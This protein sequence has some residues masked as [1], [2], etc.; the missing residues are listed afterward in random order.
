MTTWC[1]VNF[2]DE[3]IQEVLKHKEDNLSAGVVTKDSESGL[4]KRNSKVSWIK[5]KDICNKVFVQLRNQVASFNSHIHLDNI[6][7]L[8][9]SEYSSNE[10]Y[11]W[12]RDTHHDPYPD[13][14]IRK[15]SFSVFLNNNFSGGEFDLELY[16]PNE[17]KRY[18]EIK[19]KQN[20]NCIIFHSDMWH[21]VRPVTKGIR[22]S[23]VGWTLGPN[24]S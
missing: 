15:I 1:L 2:P 4:I 6:E 20:A 10:E 3:L 7:P 23:I 5:N 8:Q 22:K 12:H 11:G 9:Y 14:R 19:K 24:F 16:G 17:S 13:G 21:R 18:I